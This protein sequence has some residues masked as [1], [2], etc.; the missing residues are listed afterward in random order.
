[1]GYVAGSGAGLYCGGEEQEAL[2]GQKEYKSKGYFFFL[3]LSF[4]PSCFFLSSSHFFFS[5]LR[6]NGSAVAVW[7]RR[8]RGEGVSPPARR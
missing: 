2:K 1:M 4:V 8:R 5:F 3:L 6:A 7:G